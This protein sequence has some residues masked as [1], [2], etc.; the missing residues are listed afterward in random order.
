MTEQP[1][2]P[3]RAR[4]T[5]QPPARAAGRSDDAEQPDTQPLTISDYAQIFGAP[6]APHGYDPETGKAYSGRGNLAVGVL[7]LI[8]PGAGRLYAGHYMIG[9]LQLVLALVTCGLGHAWSLIDGIVIL[10]NGGTD[11]S[12]RPLRP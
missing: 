10:V 12:G 4:R 5:E 7:N 11:A 1:P 2:R 3:H 9:L 6:G 8:L